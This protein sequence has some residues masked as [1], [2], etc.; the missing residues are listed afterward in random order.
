MW[1]AIAWVAPYVVFLAFWEPWFV[2]YRVFALPALAIATGAFVAN[3]SC[4]PKSWPMSS[5]VVALALLVGN[6]VVT[7]AP[8]LSLESN[9]RVASAIEARRVWS[10]R[11]VVIAADLTDVD[12]TFR[13]FNP[14]VMW[15]LV[16]RL[17]DADRA[18]AVALAARE[19]AIAGFEV[20]L[21]D[22]AARRIG[23]EPPPIAETIT[24]LDARLHLQLIRY[25]RYAPA[26]S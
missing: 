9:P 21:S 26:R 16:D 23:L 12:S 25:I 3:R 8:K 2:P 10:T 7:I 19:Y 6:F 18:G 13:L 4:P 5:V 24:A 14:Q 17:P 1:I 20:W 11:T 15:V 22:G